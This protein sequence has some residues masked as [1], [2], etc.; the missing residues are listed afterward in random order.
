MAFS[1]F[2]KDGGGSISAS[3]I[4]EVLGVG[5]HIEERIWN[6]IIQEVNPKGDGEIRFDDF[7]QMM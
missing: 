6:E 2:D 5:K 4:K 1:M 7:K 3:E